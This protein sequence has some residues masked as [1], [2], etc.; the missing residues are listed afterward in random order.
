MRCSRACASKLHRAIV[1][2]APPIAQPC[3]HQ[4]P[5][6]AQQPF[7]AS[8]I[9][10]QRRQSQRRAMSAA[11]SARE[12]ILVSPAWLAEN[13]SKDDVRVLDASWYLPAMGAPC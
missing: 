12:A 5:N 8:H 4:Q 6:S 11:A 1:W 3:K 10:H 13:L 7:T 9:S 2:Q